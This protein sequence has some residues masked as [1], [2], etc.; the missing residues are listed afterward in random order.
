MG[1]EKSTWSERLRSVGGILGQ[2]ADWYDRLPVLARLIVQIFGPGGVLLGFVQAATSWFPVSLPWNPPQTLWGWVFYLGVLMF[3][4]MGGIHFAQKILP[5][6]IQLLAPRRF[7]ELPVSLKNELLEITQRQPVRRSTNQAGYRN[8]SGA[9]LIRNTYD[10]DGGQ[11]MVRPTLVGETLAKEWQEKRARLRAEQV[12]SVDRTGVNELQKLYPDFREA[13]LRG[14][15]LL[16]LLLDELA[17]KCEGDDEHCPEFWVTQFVREQLFEELRDLLRT[18]AQG[19]EDKDT[20]TRKV[21][22]DFLCL[23]K[24]YVSVRIW[25]ARLGGMLEGPL[26]NRSGF[27]DWCEANEEFNK[28]LQR[29]VMQDNLSALRW[30][31]GSLISGH[32]P[33][34]DCSSE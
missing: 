19:L 33:S 28:Q 1:S 24:E 8:L 11:V 29:R 22:D 15:N 12:E 7:R 10:L 31:L 23:Y 32:G 2:V 14:W 21:Q 20:D 34:F 18:Y 9:G 27:K 13:V 16:E 25:I 3:V 26:R 4:G 17:E 6:G 5:T 30:N